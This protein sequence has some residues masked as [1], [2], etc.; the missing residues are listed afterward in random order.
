MLLAI[1]GKAAQDIDESQLINLL[2]VKKN[3][4]YHLNLKSNSCVEILADGQQ[5]TRVIQYANVKSDDWPPGLSTNYF[6]TGP[7][8]FTITILGTGQT[9]VFNSGE[10][11]LS[12]IDKTYFRGYNFQ[13]IQFIRQDTLI[14]LGGTGFWRN[15][16]IATFFHKSLYEWELY[17]NI[18]ENGP[19]GISSQFGG[20]SS[21]EDRIY[22]LE[23]PKIY[24]ENN[25][26]AYNFY[27][28][29]FQGRKWQE[30]GKVDFKRT[31][32]KGFNKF[33]SQWIAPYFFSYEIALGEY[34]DPIENKIYRY[35]GKNIAFFHLSTQVY[36][37]G[38]YI[39]SFLR[40]Y[41]RN[42]FDLKLDSMTID[43]LKKNSIVLGHFYT[44]NIWYNEINWTQ[45]INFLILLIVAILALTLFRFI[46]NKKEK[47]L[48][49]WN[50]LPEQGE[51]FLTFL[52][53][54]ANFT[55][56]TEK[57]NEILQ[58][59]GKTIESQRQSRS[60]FIS[61]INLFFERNHGCHEAI[62]RHQSDVD[63]R[64]VN[65]VISP[66]AVAIFTKKV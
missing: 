2:D 59:E 35:R 32:L 39:Y 57:L 9:Y 5:Q 41:N 7:D 25:S 54:Q 33:A 29:D 66:E 31:E 60:K 36:L 4:L 19:Q 62:R 14:S 51:L 40:T 20:Y 55:C 37:K 43:Q 24:S 48:N 45:L 58:C 53:A 49:S 28:F 21:K 63:K 12:R 56:T 30:L 52:C 38:N 47:E 34:I 15:H 3:K 17:G 42:K 64:F 11:L 26:Y 44:P 13:P 1:V 46:K 10:C 22:C 18:S 65:Y 61:S 16:N 27:R 6:Q 50:Q 23:F 8:Q